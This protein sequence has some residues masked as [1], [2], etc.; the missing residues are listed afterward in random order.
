MRSIAERVGGNEG[1]GETA[2]LYV[3]YGY[4]GTPLGWDG[5]GFEFIDDDRIH[6]CGACLCVCVRL[7]GVRPCV[8]ACCAFPFGKKCAIVTWLLPL[9]PMFVVLRNRTVPSPRQ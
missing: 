7:R 3:A 6:Y 1:R 2:V 5:F 4:T 9:G 8:R